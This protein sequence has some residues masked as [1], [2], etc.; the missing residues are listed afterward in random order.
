M[1]FFKGGGIFFWGGEGGWEGGGVLA[2]SIRNLVPLGE[3]GVKQTY[4][5][6]VLLTFIII[7]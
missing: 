2:A 6:F 3:L 5:R 1:R 7:Y 4:K